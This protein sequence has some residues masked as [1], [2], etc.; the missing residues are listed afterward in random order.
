MEN[1][2]HFWDTKYAD[3]AYFYGEHPNEYFRQRLE[4]TGP[5]ARVLMLAE[6]EG[7]NAVYAA[8]TGRKV[9]AVDLSE[10]GRE[11]ALQ[12]AASHGVE[13]DYEIADILHFPIVEQGPWDCIALIYTHLP[14]NIRRQV[15]SACVQALRPGGFIVLEAF[16]PRQLIRTSGGPKQT[17][18]LY[19]KEMLD[20]DFASLKIVE[21]CEVTVI[22]H[23]GPG[24][25]GPAEVTRCFAQKQ[26]P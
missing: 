8:K 10:R 23:E 6:G 21:A 4:E 13:I 20:E 16:N 26:A 9:T 18:L 14:P 24:H 3:Q 22:L 2:A 19:T 11:K 17:D 15:H 1:P 5:N 25:E 7:R 12:L